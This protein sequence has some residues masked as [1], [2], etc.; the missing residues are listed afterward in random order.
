MLIPDRKKSF[1]TTITASP[2]SNH[3]DPKVL[4]NT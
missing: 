3:H 4:N 2:I 1:N